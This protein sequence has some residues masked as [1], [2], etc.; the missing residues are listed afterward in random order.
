[1]PVALI[2]FFFLHVNM[3]S[4]LAPYYMLVVLMC[5]D[6]LWTLF[7]RKKCLFVFLNIKFSPSSKLLSMEACFH[8]RIK[9]LKN[10]LFRNSD[11]ITRAVK[12]LIAINRIQN[13]FVFT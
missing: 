4:E 10:F 1:M 9:N 11:F 7:L 5:T 13:K 8:H 6:Y 2:Y 12:Q 3:K